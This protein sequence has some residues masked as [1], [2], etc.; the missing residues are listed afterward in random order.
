MPKKLSLIQ[1][2]CLIFVATLLPG[3]I[4]HSQPRDTEK[5][6][7]DTTVKKLV[8]VSDTLLKKTKGEQMVK[9]I[10][11][12]NKRNKLRALQENLRNSISTE[13]DN[14]S[15]YFRKGIDT[16]GLNKELSKLDDGYNAAA[17]GILVNPIVPQTARN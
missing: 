3:M 16:A 10:T 17:D 7:L 9:Q 2:F 1:L 15:N 13:L 14:V 4:I 8:N 6:A 12:L 5:S 11:E